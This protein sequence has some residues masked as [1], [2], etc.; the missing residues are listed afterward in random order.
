VRYELAVIFDVVV[1]YSQR[2][3]EAQVL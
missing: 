3:L 2:I 1:D